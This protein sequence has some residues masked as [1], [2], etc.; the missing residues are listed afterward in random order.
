MTESAYR[1]FAADPAKGHVFA[2]K[3]G[4]VHGEDVRWDCS[5][6]HCW[7]WVR[8]YGEP[9]GPALRAACSTLIGRG[10]VTCDNCSGWW[11]WPGTFNDEKHARAYLSQHACGAASM[12]V[13]V[14]QPAPDS[15]GDLFPE[16]QV[17]TG[18]RGNV[19]DD[20]RCTCCRPSHS[21]A[22]QTE[23]RP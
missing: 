14:I 22:S 4:I 6:C 18:V 21:G 17:P 19:D 2:E 23:D 20:V 11:E 10:R 5:V 13:R 3:P 15:G 1:T 7:V 8:K 12:R 9:Y 16:C